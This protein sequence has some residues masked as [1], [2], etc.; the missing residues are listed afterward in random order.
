MTDSRHE[1]HYTFRGEL[2]QRVV[3]D[4]F[5]PTDSSEELLV[6]PP[7]TTYPIGV[8]FPKEQPE[9]MADE[10]DEDQDVD[11]TLVSDVVKARAKDEENNEAGVPLANRHKP[12]AAGITFAV[13]THRVAELSIDVAAARYEPVDEQGNRTEAKRAQTRTT[14]DTG[15]RWKRSY[16]RTTSIRLPVAEPD[17]RW[18]HPVMKGLELQAVIRPADA[19]GVAAVTL[20]LVNKEDAPAEGM[21]DEYCFF[22]PRLVVRAPEGSHALVERRRRGRHHDAELD[23]MRL[24]YRYA[25]AFAT[26][27]G[28]AADWTW[29][30]PTPNRMPD[31]EERTGIDEV[32]IAFVPSYEVL[33]TDSNPHIDTGSLGMLRLSEAT[34]HDVVATLRTLLGG[35]EKWIGERE[36]DAEELAATEFGDMAREQI[37]LCK[38]VLKRM[39]S[40][41]DRL[42]TDATCMEAFQF[43][44]RAMADQ[45]ARSDWIKGDRQGTPQPEKGEW[46]PFQICFVLLCLD[47]VADPTHSDRE[48]ADLLWFP[49]G[50]GKTEAYLGLMAFTIFL[51]RLR[52]G[53]AG[54]GVTVLMRYTLRL[55]TLQQFERATALMCAME[56]IR[57]RVG[58]RLGTEKITIGMWVGQ[59]ATPNHLKDARKNLN[60]LQNGQPVPKENPVQLRACPW[61]GTGLGPE[62]YSVTHV[63]MS[64]ECP[65]TT[66]DFHFGLP[67]HVIDETVY[68]AR[69]T[70]VIATVDKYAMVPW[71]ERA[72]ALFNRNRPADDTPPPELI[73]QDELHLISG[74]LGTLTGLYETMVDLAANTP[75]VI[76]STATIRRAKQ[77]GQALF[78]REVQ[79]FPPTGLDARD[80]WFSVET[81]S[82]DKASRRY[83]GLLAPATSQSSLLV[84]A[85]AALLHNAAGIEGNEEVRDAYLTLVGYFNSLRIL[86][87]AE[88]Q[89]RDDVDDRLKLLAERDG[90]DQR[91]LDEPTELT[92]RV[93]ASDIPTYLKDLE[94]AH[95]LRSVVDVLLATNMISVGV[96]VDRLGLMAIMG[97]P[98]T[99][100]EYIQSSSRVGRKHPGLVVTLYNSSRSRDRSHYENFTAYHSALYRQVESTSV[101]PFSPRARD[102]ALHAVLIGLARVM[103]EKARPKSAAGKVEQFVDALYELAARIVDRARDIALAE[104]DTPEDSK[105]V[106]AAD[107][108]AADVES[109]LQ[110][111]IEAW[112]DYAEEQNDYS[113]GFVY[114]GWR[115]A[116]PAL[117][118]PYAEA[119]EGQLPFATLTSMRA[120]DAE[121][122]LF[123]EK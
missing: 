65:N 36:R 27:H 91:E 88:L 9:A 22:Q 4:L 105:A 58:H 14:G 31:P 33:L 123:E 55:L 113:E 3:R 92:S 86:A 5:G 49:T 57:L 121:S 11:E 106:E 53:P 95:P 100:A 107:A 96:D 61:C 104:F 122:D 120:V 66:C 78:R 42:A 25:P 81:P 26:G 70:L 108:L 76:A 69:P 16:A 115:G 2:E 32:R 50:G 7:V 44:N 102:R 37:A 75:K 72:A 39:H 90:C 13:D 20:T 18:H 98:Q 60:K 43:A 28:C 29:Q 8:L 112:R 52:L 21:Q 51:R 63:A 1:A 71:Q 82:K 94:R 116:R 56:M 110:A 34:S 89:V 77:Q 99:T 85:Y 97:Q 15:V 23:V 59:S 80:S 67:V 54:G 24:L 6:D 109:E 19:S 103:I 83:V 111:I 48:V 93:D 101:T 119:E 38:Q 62:H 74:P 73:I 45:R 84:R 114:E 68:A 79:Q 12:S 64:V 40:G 47:G 10:P 46:R 17:P 87:A 118:A 117:L 35:Y 41:V 30:P